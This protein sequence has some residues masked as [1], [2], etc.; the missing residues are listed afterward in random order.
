[1]SQKLPTVSGVE[2]IKALQRVGFAVRRQK[3]SH[4]HLVRDDDKKRVTVPVHGTIAIAKGTLRAI[5][6]DADLTVE[7]LRK[8]L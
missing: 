7:D 5:L 3:G 8:L 1:V 6:R 2:L 4:V